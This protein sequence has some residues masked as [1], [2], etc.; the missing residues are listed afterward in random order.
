MSK[1]GADLRYGPRH[2]AGFKANGDVACE[3][4]FE[5]KL[6][7]DNLRS[8]LVSVK[9]AKGIKAELRQLKAEN[10]KLKRELSNYRARTNIIP[11]GAHTPSSQRVFK[12]GTPAENLKKRGG[13]VAG[14][15][16]AGRKQTNTSDADVLIKV[17]APESCPDCSTALRFHSERNRTVLDVAEIKV[18]KTLYVVERRKCGN[19][20]TLHEAK[21]NLFPRA[22]YS[23]ALLSQVA[24]MHYV[25]GVPIGRICELLGKDVNPSGILAA[26]HR[27]ANLW[28]P[29]LKDLIELF[30]AS[31]VKHAD[32]TSWRTDGQPGWSWIFCTPRVSI[33][34][35]QNNRSSRVPLR[36]FGTEK[37]SGTLVVDR[38]AAYNRMPCQIQ[39]CYAHLLREVK[40]LDEEFDDEHEVSVFA[41][42]LSHLLSCAMRLQNQPLSDAHYY[43]Q[44]NSLAEQIKALAYR[45]C[46]HLG[47]HNIQHIFRK[48]EPRL[49][50]W[51][52]DRR[53]PAHNN[54]AERE[55]RQTVIARKVSF[56]SQ[57]ENGA[58][59]RSTLMSVLI[60]AKKTLN[61]SLEAWFTEAL[62]K[63]ALDPS[64]KPASLLPVIP[65]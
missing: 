65:P 5:K 26:L 6:L 14:H 31:P 47:I 59:T 44:A 40:K 35:C 4:C 38:F 17:S 9:K 25:H 12:K 39:Y 8:E 15:S 43:F 10:I 18:R 23:N 1:R 19:C 36:I 7:I 3:S 41:D 32:E 34:E 28:E 33:F 54:R 20:M 30:R 55:L 49:Y 56:G 37:L 60:T 51:A 50:H 45:E 22:L 53:V 24:V 46:R 64:I 29:A 42:E 52:F 62:N 27:I 16:G 61:D 63:I 2:R 57:S 48:N 21:L 13:A 58:R 11:I